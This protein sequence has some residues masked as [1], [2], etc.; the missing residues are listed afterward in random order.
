MTVHLPDKTGTLTRNEMTVQRIVC[1]DH[2]IDVSGVGY[3]PT[4][5]YSIDGHHRPCSL[6]GTYPGDSF[7]SAVTMPCYGKKMAL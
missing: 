1:A 7:R 2:T 3:V 6:S 4:G 5:E